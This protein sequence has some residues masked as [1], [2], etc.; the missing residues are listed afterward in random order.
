LQQQGAQPGDVADG[1]RLSLGAT[2]GGTI[3]ALLLK[4]GDWRVVF[5][6]GA[7]AT[8]VFIPLVF[9]LVPETP[10]VVPGQPPGR[11]AGADQPL[12]RRAAPAGGD[13]PAPVEPE[14]ARASLLDILRPGLLGTT[15]L[16]TV[17]YRSTASRS[18]TSSSGA[19]RSL[20]TSAIPSR[21]RPACWSGPI[22]A[23]RS[24]AACSGS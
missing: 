8:L 5:E 16:L 9:F 12:A 18:T 4:S 13:R 7:I 19:P 6:F 14:A 23:G 11:C 24:V 17:G 2:V 21:R 10:G 15:L 3:A 22:S 20:P 1:H